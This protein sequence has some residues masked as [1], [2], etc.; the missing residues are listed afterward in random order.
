MFQPFRIK[1]CDCVSIHAESQG[2]KKTNFATGIRNARVTPE[3]LL[4][5]QIVRNAGMS[6]SRGTPEEG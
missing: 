1:A 3:L 5:S 6:E 4:L 2:R